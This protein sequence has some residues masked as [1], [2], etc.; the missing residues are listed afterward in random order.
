V[1]LS[2]PI[3]RMHLRLRG[4]SLPI[5]SRKRLNSVNKVKMLS[6]GMSQKRDGRL[7]ERPNSI[8]TWLNLPALNFSRMPTNN[9]KHSDQGFL[10]SR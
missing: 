2:D 5:M 4:I 9:S 8:W 1:A 7:G 3:I 6:R 10:L